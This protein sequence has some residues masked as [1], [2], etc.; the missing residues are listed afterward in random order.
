VLFGNAGLSGELPDTI[1]REIVCPM[2]KTK[3][4]FAR[5][6]EELML[7][8]TAPTREKHPSNVRVARHQAHERSDLARKLLIKNK[9]QKYYNLTTAGIRLS[10]TG[11]NL[12]REK[13]DLTRACSFPALAHL[14]MGEVSQAPR[15]ASVSTSDR[16]PAVVV[17]KTTG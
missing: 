8:Q 17:Q 10:Y 5:Q 7:P 9:L 14:S 6:F 2:M 15:C 3:P 1:G 12:N 11:L 13:R 16:V 4:V